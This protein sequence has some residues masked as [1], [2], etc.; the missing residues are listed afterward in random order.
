M[1]MALFQVFVGI[2]VS[3]DWL[4]VH[5]LAIRRRLRVANTP[6]G[7]RELADALAEHPQAK[8]GFEASGGYEQGVL[9]HLAEAGWQVYCLDPYKVRQFAR[10]AGRRAKNDRIDAEMIARY[11]ASF[12]LQPTRIDPL[13]ER[14]SEYVTYRRQL[15]E[16]RTA[17]ANQARL[18]HDPALR[19][20]SRQRL[21]RLEV[22]IARLEKA[23][24]EQIAGDPQLAAKAAVL[25]TLK[26]VGPTLAATLLALLPELGT[27][28]RRKIAA[29]V[30]LCP[31]DFD[32]G[33][34]AGQ[35]HIA[36]G[37][38]HV[39]TALYMPTLTAMRF[40]PAI[41]PFYERCVTGRDNKKPAVIAAMRKLL[42]I[43]NARMRDHLASLDIDQNNIQAAQ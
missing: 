19:R 25:R 11:L 37:R 6:A 16:E 8:V 22:L 31:Y 7:W 2:D 39:R 15:V 27:I 43:L 33:R 20:L 26:G 30:G 3:R 28:C 13:V 29:L 10:A 24:A 5:I 23:L 1:K 34:F 41:K 36:G 40:E 38:K 42:T 18:L 32:S 17:V 9:H 14:L 4:D 12:T 21:A 35:R